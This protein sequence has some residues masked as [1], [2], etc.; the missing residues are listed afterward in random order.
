MP[1]IKKG[2]TIQNQYCAKEHVITVTV[3]SVARKCLQRRAKGDYRGV[4]GEFQ[5]RYREF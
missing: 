5:W 1:Y 4:L 2:T 3:A